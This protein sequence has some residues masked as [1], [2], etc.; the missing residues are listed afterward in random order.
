[1][2]FTTLVLLAQMASERPPAELVSP[3]PTSATTG[4]PA[5]GGATAQD[6]TAYESDVPDEVER[7]SAEQ[8]AEMEEL[9]ALE[10]VALD[11]SA[12]PNAD[13]LQAMRRM[14]M[15]SPLRGRMESAFAEPDL[16]E[17][18]SPLELPRIKDLAKFDI[19]QVKSRYDI[20]MEMQP[21]VAQYIQF[22]QGPGRKW[23]RKWMSRSTR[24]IPAMEPILESNGLP[25]DT[26]YLAMIES[27]FSPQAYSWA[28][29]AGP[30]QFIPATARLYGL[31]QDFWVDERRDPTKST[32]AAARYLHQLYSDLGDWYLA[33]AA[34]NAGGGKLSRMIV[35]KGTYD[36]WQLSDG[37]GLAKETK[38]YVPK[39]I[40]C[41][42]IAKHPNAFGFDDREFAFEVPM[43]TE[44][45]KLAEAVDLET[46]AKAA[47]I[48]VDEV[49]EL[50]P[51]LKRW[52]TPPASAK[53]P[54]LLRLPKG[55]GEKFTANFAKLGPQARLAF[56]VHRVK[57]GD[58]LSQI[59]ASY[60]SA[61]EAI[62]RLNG[63]RSVKLLRVNSELV[64]PVPTTHGKPDPSLERQVVRAR[65]GGFVAIRPEEEIPAGTV[66]RRA[67]ASGPLT[68][69]VIDGKTRVTYGVQSGDTLWAISQR[70]N[71]TVDDLRRWNR[72]SKR[73]RALQVGTVLVVWPK[74]K[75]AAIQGEQ[76]L[77]LSANERHSAP[78]S[79]R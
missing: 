48:T 20:P 78:A 11:P 40:A 65:R 36:F 38:H 28:R 16:R 54:Y 26:V 18:L 62:L 33:W 73:K 69:E 68:S 51:E 76:E 50:N 30:W 17:D 32:Q 77:L 27:G 45:V 63:L 13:I 75:T 12:K 4:A 44:E 31:K 10:E 14:G 79:A 47:E 59:A 25:K 21:L 1:M 8:S 74:P 37:K 42:L 52:C 24:Y 66:V 39:L 34:Y 72:L 41:A 64:V 29:A 70:F 19:S 7:Q 60:H 56:R 2:L 57:R 43:E 46:V 55:A 53:Q 23:F 15:A 67:V 61:P 5:R 6:G 35:R 9:R 49:R 3:R 58:T 22:F 71:C